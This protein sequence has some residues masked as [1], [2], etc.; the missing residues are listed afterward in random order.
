MMV[1]WGKQATPAQGTEDII[2]GRNEDF[3]QK[4]CGA[5]RKQEKCYDKNLYGSNRLVA[6]AKDEADDVLLGHLGELL[7]EN[8]L[9]LAQVSH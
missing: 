7:P 9:E 6:L 4:K 2:D 3:T 8:L 5:A 1:T